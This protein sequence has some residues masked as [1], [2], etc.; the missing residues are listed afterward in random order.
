MSTIMH[1]SRPK[2]ALVT[3][4]SR[5]IEAGVAISLAQ[6]G[7]AVSV[8]Y[9]EKHRRA[10]GVAR[11]IE[12]L[13]QACQLIKGDL[14]HEDEIESVVGHALQQV[15]RLPTVDE[16]SSM[17]ASVAIEEMKGID[18]STRYCGSIAPYLIPV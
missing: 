11:T 3:G 16:F 18:I 10:V 4:A 14:S 12:E 6:R 17:I 1:I 7:L 8:C 9:R 5:G 13:G 15:G 2:R